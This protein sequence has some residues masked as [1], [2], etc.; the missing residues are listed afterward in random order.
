MIEG[1]LGGEVEIS[2]EVVVKKD[3]STIEMDKQVDITI[4]KKVE[5]TASSDQDDSDL[6]S[7]STTIE[8]PAKPEPVPH[9]H[10][11]LKYLI[12]EYDTKKQNYEEYDPKKD[13]DTQSIT[14]LGRFYEPPSFEESSNV[15]YFI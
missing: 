3:G 8:E 12:D 4:T 5:F 15:E 2:R 9:K 13:P 14:S 10:A 6:E 7:E 11:Y 1:E